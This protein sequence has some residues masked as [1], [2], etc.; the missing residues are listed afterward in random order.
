MFELFDT[1]PA[2]PKMLRHSMIVF[3][4]ISNA[5]LSAELESGS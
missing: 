4:G 5:E 2:V 1:G 3:R